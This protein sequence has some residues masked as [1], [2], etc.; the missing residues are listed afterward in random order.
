V[1]DPS[2][3]SHQNKCHV[4]T[5]VFLVY[6]MNYNFLVYIISLPVLIGTLSPR[7][8]RGVCVTPF[9][10]PSRRC[11]T[12]VGKRGQKC[13]TPIVVGR[14]GGQYDAHPAAHA[15]TRQQQ[16]SS[17]ALL[18]GRG[19]LEA[20]SSHGWVAAGDIPNAHI[21]ERNYIGKDYTAQV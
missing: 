19:D 17:G 4:F 18:W 16:D 2:Q 15:L 21:S 13:D 3:Q 7:V 12:N 8:G 6:I 9:L 10:T 5:R 20:C 14:E 11:C 1:F